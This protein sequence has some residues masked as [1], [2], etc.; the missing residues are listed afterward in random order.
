MIYHE[1][2]IYRCLIHMEIRH[3]VVVAMEVS[4]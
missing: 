1:T 3:G 4:R 2:L